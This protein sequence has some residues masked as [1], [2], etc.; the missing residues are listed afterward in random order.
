METLMSILSTVW[1]LMN[2]PA[3]ITIIVSV[4][5]WIGAKIYSAAPSW[6]KYEGAIIEAIKMAEKTIPDDTENKAVRKFDT[7]LRYV[8]K[9][10]RETENRAAKPKEMAVLAE[11]I[12]L[13]HNAL[14]IDGTLKKDD[15][16]SK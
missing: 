3:G 12:R 5:V 6:Q 9:I 11:G 15:V 16:V 10:H 1:A 8:L 13:V 14:E 7:A 2:S 4:V